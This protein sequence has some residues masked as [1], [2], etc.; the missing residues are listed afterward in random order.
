MGNSEGWDVTGTSAQSPFLPIHHVSWW[1]FFHSY[2]QGK[3]GN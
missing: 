1:P 3:W 2:T